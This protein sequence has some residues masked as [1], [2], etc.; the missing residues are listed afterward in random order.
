[1][2]GALILLRVVP[3]LAVLLAV[4]GSLALAGWAVYGLECEHTAWRWSWWRKGNV[5]Q[6]EI[7]QRIEDV[8]R[9][10]GL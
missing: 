1:M 7:K 8:L 9:R 5:P 10:A 6:G 3:V 2:L 4:L